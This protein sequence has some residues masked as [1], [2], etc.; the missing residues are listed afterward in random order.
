MKN[1]RFALIEAILEIH[2][3][4]KRVHLQRAFGLAPAGATRTITE[5]R[6]T[7]P[8]HIVFKPGLKCYV[9]GDKFE[10]LNLAQFNVDSHKFYEAA[11]IMAGETIVLIENRVA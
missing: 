8:D 6:E 9:K 5:Y 11:C 7:H 10:T 3:A 2:G 1:Q 4:I